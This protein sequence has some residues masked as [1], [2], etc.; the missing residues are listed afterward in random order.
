M[1]KEFWVMIIFG[2]IIVALLGILMWP[3]IKPANNNNQENPPIDDSGLTITVPAPNA[4]VS[5]PFVI[6]GIA[7][8]DGW[9]GFEGQV[10][11]VDLLDSDGNGLG[12]A[13]LTATTDW[14]SPPVN[15]EAT[16]NFATSN[17]GPGTLVFH[18]EN[19]SGDP[20]MNRTFSMPVNIIASPAETMTVKAFFG[21]DEITGST[22]SVVFPVERIVPKTEAVARASLEE[23]L[24]GPTDAEMSDGYF[25]NINSGVK[26]QSLSIDANGTAHVDFSEELET[27]GGSCR[28]IEIRSEINYTLKQFST[29][30]DVIISINGRTED[31]LQP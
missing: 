11:I 23:L 31:I 27:T 7:N 20:A 30:K 17:S 19:A 6:K 10:G 21:K 4:E 2:I 9:N 8:L 12:Y 22:C 13:I 26:I 18:N 5:S 3:S 1:K 24:K 16:L 25:S 29:V 28:V 15:F 14:M